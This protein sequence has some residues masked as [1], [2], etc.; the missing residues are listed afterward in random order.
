MIL[1]TSKIW[2]KS[3]PVTLPIIT[4]ILQKIQETYGSI[5]GNIIFVHMGTKKIDCFEMFERH[6]HHL[7]ENMFGISGNYF[8]ENMLSTCFL[9]Y[10]VW[11]RG[12]ENDKLS[13]KTFAKAWIWFSYLSKNMKWEFGKSFK[14]MYFQVMESLNFFIFKKGN[15]ITSISR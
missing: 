3:W 12:S 11:W 9:T 15:H 4:K 13:I 6:T 2:S 1:G 14:F 8:F 10:F 5:L 7:L